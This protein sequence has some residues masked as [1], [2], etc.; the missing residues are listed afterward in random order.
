MRTI[1]PES[2]PVDGVIPTALLWAAAGIF[3]VG[4]CFYASYVVGRDNDEYDRLDSAL[5]K[6]TERHAA[7][8][9]QVRSSKQR[10]QKIETEQREVLA[11]YGMIK[12]LSEALSW[13]DMR[14]K[15]ELAIRQYLG[16]ESFSLYVTEEGKMRPIARRRL[17]SSVGANWET[18]ERYLQER[19]LPVRVP[20]IIDSPERAVAVPIFEGDKL[21]GYFY[22]RSPKGAD[23]PTLL[24]KA[25]A[26][27]EEISFAFRR[28]RLFQEVERHSLTDGLTGLYRRGA[29]DQKIKE[30][31]IRGRT[32]KTTFCLMILDIDHFKVLNDKY[33]HPFGDEVLARVSAILQENVYETDFV[34]RYGGE[35]FAILLPRAQMEGVLRKA[36]RLRQ[37]VEASAT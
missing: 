33:G 16:V 6:R 24:S 31:V 30:E 21:T 8:R 36:E 4:A 28:V 18:L 13:E 19:N 14:P 5:R 1:D 20:H 27:V 9:D 2:D 25:E 23:G 26:F 3:S 29:L 22:V 35:E 12:G 10:I 17:G 11:I 7:V 34:A 15:L 32:F 37:A